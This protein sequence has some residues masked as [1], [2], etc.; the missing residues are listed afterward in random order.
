VLGTVAG[1]DTV[2]ALLRSAGHG[3]RLLRKIE[4]LLT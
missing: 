2:C 4:D 3:R 1:D